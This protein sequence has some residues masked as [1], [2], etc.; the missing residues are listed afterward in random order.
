MNSNLKCRILRVPIAALLLASTTLCV[1]LTLLPNKA[2]ALVP[3]SSEE[4]SFAQTPA[5]DI[6]PQVVTRRSLYDDVIDTYR[7]F[8]GIAGGV[9]LQDY[10]Y[11][12]TYKGLSYRQ[13]YIRKAP[14]LLSVKGYGPGEL[15]IPG[16]GSATGSVEVWKYSYEVH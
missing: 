11:G 5:V 2:I 3:S 15:Y 7:L 16:Y 12:E 13:Y 4:L 10:Y 9:A 14:T 6:P 1:S 8:T